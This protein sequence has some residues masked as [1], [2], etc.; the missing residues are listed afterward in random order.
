AL[1]SKLQREKDVL[2]LTIRDLETELKSTRKTER[3]F[4]LKCQELNRTKIKLKEVEEQLTQIKSEDAP[5]TKLISGQLQQTQDEVQG[6]REQTGRL[7]D[8]ID[9][10]LNHLSLS[11]IEP[12]GRASAPVTRISSAQCV[13]LPPIKK[14]K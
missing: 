11:T 10:L 14:G 9:L 3:S 12:P 5:D 6:L 2:K 7:E 8:K 4:T 13:K 1:I